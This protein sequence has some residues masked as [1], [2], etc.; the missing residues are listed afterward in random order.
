V[1]ESEREVLCSQCTGGIVDSRME[2][3]ASQG[4]VVYVLLSLHGGGGVLAPCWPEPTAVRYAVE[5]KDRHG[6][7]WERGLRVEGACTYR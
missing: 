5:T 6:R 4:Y 3:A 1:L 2:G 7:C